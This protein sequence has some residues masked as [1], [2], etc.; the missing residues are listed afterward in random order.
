MHAL[1][2]DIQNFSIHN[3][4]G[5]RTTVF[6]K[7]CPLNCQWCHNPESI[8]FEKTMLLD[9][10]KCSLCGY[11][12]KLCNGARKIEGDKLI[13][14]SENCNFCKECT[15]FCMNDCNKI[16][17]KKYQVEELVN[18]LLKD[19]S[20]YNES[21]GGITF[22]GGEAL[23]HS[24]YLLEVIKKLKDY[25]IDITIDTCGYV[26]YDNFNK[27]IDKVDTFLYDLKIMDSDKHYKYIGVPNEKIIDNLIKLSKNHNDIIIRIPLIKEVN[28]NID[29]IKRV[30]S[31]MKELNLKKVDLLPYHKGGINKRKQLNMKI[32]EFESPNKIEVKE[33]KKLFEKEGLKVRIGG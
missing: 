21:G 7:G 33:I 10:E 24:D 22:S 6:F 26:P 32:Y 12:I 3:G 20:F 31:L 25:D 15:I 18:I 16:V 28:S 27:V 19:L 13:I 30:I 11:C 29:N 8:S 1:I 9:S 23:C 14:E 2:Y 4:N 5:I 17:G